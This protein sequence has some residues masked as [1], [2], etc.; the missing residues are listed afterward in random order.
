MDVPR[1]KGTTKVDMSQL[2]VGGV[3]LLNDDRIP[4]T[5]RL[6]RDI[7]EF[8]EATSMKLTLICRQGLGDARIWARLMNGG[9]ITVEKADE[10]YAFMASKGYYFNS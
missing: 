3:V 4:W 2:K 9:T 5:D 6:K 1:V 10:L 8:H 7:L